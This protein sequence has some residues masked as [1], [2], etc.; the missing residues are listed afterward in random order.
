M[1]TTFESYNPPRLTKSKNYQPNGMF[2]DM[3][4][5]HK[6]LCKNCGQ[7]YGQHY[8]EDDKCPT[9]EQIKRR[10]RNTKDWFKSHK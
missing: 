5:I 10:I 2:Y 3:P 4:I 8:M 7:P 6:R 1:K 9:K